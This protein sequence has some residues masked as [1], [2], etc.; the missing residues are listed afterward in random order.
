MKKTDFS[1]DNPSYIDSNDI[2]LKD[3]FD[4]FLRNRVL[5]GSITVIFL[6]LS[7]I[8]S[9]FKKD[10]WE[11]RL[12]IVLDPDT[13]N[14]MP[15]NLLNNVKIPGFSGMNVSKQSSLATE[16]VILESPFVL[17]PVFD[18]VKDEKNKIQKDS[19]NYSF[20]SW[21]KIT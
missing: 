20:S 18:F 2:D 11:G 13:T 3:V 17:M 1:K 15:F 8:Y 14:K 16:V 4:F 12:Q 21:R 9:A 5:V 6:L 19:F 10:I 7:F